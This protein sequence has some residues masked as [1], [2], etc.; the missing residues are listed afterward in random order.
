M[1]RGRGVSALWGGLIG[2]EIAE[3]VPRSLGCARDDSG[4]KNGSRDPPLQGAGLKPGLYKINGKSGRRSR[5]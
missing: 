5:R 1:K 3:S 2:R 4:K